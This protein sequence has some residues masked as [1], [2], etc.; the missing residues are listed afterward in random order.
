MKTCIEVAEL[1]ISAIYELGKE[2]K[3]S[4]E[5]IEAKAKAVSE[6][7]RLVGKATANLKADGIPATLIGNY[8]K[9]RTYQALYDRIVAE[10]TMKAHYSRL[11]QLESILNGYQSLNRYLQTVSQG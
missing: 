5:L 3:R 11:S 10:E 7:E 4:E 2:G 9:E 6:H 1:I 8:V